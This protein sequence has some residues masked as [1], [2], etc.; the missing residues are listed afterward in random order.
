MEGY[1]PKR[2]EE[3]PNLTDKRDTDTHA[4]CLVGI[5]INGICDQDRGDDL[6]PHGTNGRANN[7]C[8]GPVSVRCC[9]GADQ[10]DNQTDDGQGETEVAEPDP[11]LWLWLSPKSAFALLHPE[12]GHDTAKLL[13]DDGADDKA[14]ELETYLL[15]VQIEF[16]FQQVWDLDCGQ[17]TREKEDHRICGSRD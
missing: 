14:E 5:T 12:I 9:L 17:D 16:C 10:E 2:P 1:S 11:V 15:W 4:G 7:G 8:Y 6:V 13:T 3:S